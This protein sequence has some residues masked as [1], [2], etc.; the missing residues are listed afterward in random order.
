MIKRVSFEEELAPLLPLVQMPGRYSG[1]E[2]G[3]RKGMDTET[4]DVVI[5]IAFPDLYEIGMSNLAVKLLYRELNNREGVRCERVF[6]PAPD[7]EELLRKHQIP[8]ST[9]ESG[10]ALSSLD[11]L[12]ISIGYEL[13]ATNI[14][15]LLA[16][17]GISLE[18]TARSG[19][20]PLVIAGGPAIT[21][22]APFARFFDGI[23]VGE[24]EEVM[25]QLIEKLRTMKEMKGREF[26]R[27]DGLKLLNDH[28]SVW[29][30]DKSERGEKTVR[31]VWKGF[32]RRQIGYMPVPNIKVVQDH[33]VVEIMRGCPNGCRFCHAGILY[34]P[35]R[36]KSVKRII[37]EVDYLVHDLGYREVTLSS[38]SSGDYSGLDTVVKYLHRRYEQWGV[39][40]A[41]P[42]L[43]I[44]S[45]T[46]PLLREISRVRKSG[47]TFAVETPLVQWQRG[48]NKEVPLEKVIEILREAKQQGWFM[49]KFYFMIG[50]PVRVCRS[51]KRDYGDESDAIIAFLQRV[52]EESGFKINANIGTF[53]PKAHTPFQWAGQLGEY[54]ARELIR[55]MQ[56]HF[57]RSPV[58]IAYHSPFISLLEGVFSRG[59]ERVADLI[60][61]AYEKGARLDAWEEHLSVDIWRDVFAAAGWD[62]EK[63]TCRSRDEEEKLPWESLDLGI[64]K[65][66][67]LEEWRKAG[68]GET[69]SPC[70]F[71][72]THHCGVCR[73]GI[74][75][76]ESETVEVPDIP[77][78]QNERIRRDSN[79]PE[80]RW[81]LFRFRKRG[82]ARFLSHIN[83]MTIFERSFQRAGIRIEHSRGYNPKP[84]LEFA[85]PLM[86][87]IES[88][89]EVCRAKIRCEESCDSFHLAEKLRGVFPEGIEVIEAGEIVPEFSR[90]K[91]KSLMALYGGSIFSVTKIDSHA[92]EAAVSKEFVDIK[93]LKEEME[94]CGGPGKYLSEQRILRKSL[95]AVDPNTGKNTDYFTLFTSR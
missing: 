83:V 48:I 50:L 23:Y 38:L 56:N 8:L 53:I 90:G 68:A 18:R 49:A 85:H 87:G 11:L 64:D 67:L 17:G 40:F 60:L 5:G 10:I 45:F 86:L 24:A 20:E 41:L 69:S 33:G 1:G 75:P 73:E 36:Q 7:F 74:R 63:E 19:T 94:A 4:G 29:T 15:A 61:R 28:P 13:A 14:L 89:A 77:T 58:R 27:T 39:S 70:L 3:A 32:G 44:D 47:I 55:K 30:K 25:P 26:R 22:P 37:E 81:F 78:E 71:P 80:G 88:D 84:R 51:H 76:I 93:R 9:L 52:R 72:C 31:A 12:G 34:R 57:Q 21:N 2:Y 54:A 43:R 92:N 91:G 95:F 42:S 79:A 66:Y 65:S 16:L 46:L 82:R 35:F 6:S 59:D 62:V